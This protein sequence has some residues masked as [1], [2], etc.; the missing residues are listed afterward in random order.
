MPEQK[1]VTLTVQVPTSS[2][3]TEQQIRD[4]AQAGVD[5]AFAEDQLARRGVRLHGA[6]GVQVGDGNTQNIVW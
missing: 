3:L 1:N 6:T 5:A 2:K 4:A